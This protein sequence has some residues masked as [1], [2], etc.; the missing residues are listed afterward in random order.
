MVTKRGSG[1]AAV[2]VEVDPDRV[3][4]VELGR[5]DQV[6]R[7]VRASGEKAIEVFGGRLMMI[8]NEDRP[9]DLRHLHKDGAL[10]AEVHDDHVAARHV[11]RFD[12]IVT[13]K[14][15]NVI[16]EA[17]P[18][19]P[20]RREAVEAVAVIDAERLGQF[21]I[22]LH[23]SMTERGSSGRPAVVIAALVLQRLQV[24]T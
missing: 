6:V 20:R 8:Q 15:V 10:V 17:L 1:A 23:G 19:S 5:F 11:W 18:D 3:G 24:T 7:F 16:A 12:A 14:E 2:H 22:S 4:R 9:R 13:L 21:G